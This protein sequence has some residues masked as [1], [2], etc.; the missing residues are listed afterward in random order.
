MTSVEAAHQVLRSL[1]ICFKNTYLHK[2]YKKLGRQQKARQIMTSVEAAHQVLRSLKICFE[3][4]LSYIIQRK[5]FQV[6]PICVFFISYFSTTGKVEI[7][8]KGSL[9]LINSPSVKIQIMCR[10]V[11]LR[12]KGKT[13]LCIVNKLFVFKSLLTIPIIVLLLHLSR[14]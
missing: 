3:N 13:L 6:T 4:M 14:P 12:R 7:F 1:K 2:K 9:N 8:L 10:K 5:R 11:C